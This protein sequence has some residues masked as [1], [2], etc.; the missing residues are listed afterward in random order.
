MSYHLWV[1]PV[2]KSASNIFLICKWFW[3]LSD[4]N[5]TFYGNKEKNSNFLFDNETL[6]ASDCNLLYFV[7]IMLQISIYYRNCWINYRSQNSFNLT[8]NTSFKYIIKII[9]VFFKLSGGSWRLNW[10]LVRFL[11]ILAVNSKSKTTT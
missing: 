9:W 3:N 4:A 5:K 2:L 8:K 6:N 11:T 10:W 7:E 1:N